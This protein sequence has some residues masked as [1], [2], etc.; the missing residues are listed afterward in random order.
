MMLARSPAG[1]S[2][3]ALGCRGPAALLIVAVLAA[4]GGAPA[5]AQTPLDRG[6]PRS[7]IYEPPPDPVPAPVPGWAPARDVGVRYELPGSAEV[8]RDFDRPVSS[9]GAGHRGIDLAVPPGEPVTVAGDGTVRHVGP[10][11]GVPWVS[12]L[13]ADGIVTSYGP[14][15]DIVVRPGQPVR[16]GQ[17][18]GVVAAGGHGDDDADRG[19]HLG[20]RRGVVY[21]DPRSLLAAGTPRPSLVGGGDWRGD[22]HVVTP[23][24]PW[25][26][27]R[28]WGLGTTPSPHAERPG[29]AVPPSPNHLV[30]LNG[31]ASSSGQTPIDPEHLGYDPR[32]VTLFSYAGRT[33]GFGEA[34]DIR[35][36]QRPYGPSDTWEGV[37]AAAERLRDQLRALRAREPGRGVDLVGHSM[38]GVVILHYLAHLHDAY[39]PTLPS[40]GRVV[41]VAAPNRGSDAAAAARY[42]REHP[43]L[44]PAIEGVR[45]VITYPD[46]STARDHLP[47]D[48]PA[49]DQLRTGS[50]FIAEHGRAWIDAVDGGTSGPLAM[51][52]RILTIGG[53]RDVVVA[54]SNAR[55]PTIALHDHPT[56]DYQGLDLQGPPVASSTVLPGG[57]GSVLDTEAVRE[58][59][60]RFLAGD[61]PPEAR[62]GV[63]AIA[64]DQLGPM[65]HVGSAMAYLYGGFVSAARRL[66]RDPARGPIEPAAPLEEHGPPRSEGDGSASSGRGE[67][68]PGAA[69]SGRAP[70]NR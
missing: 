8:V 39:D 31:L 61:E 7:P 63:S 43:V 49:V 62:G 48:A 16:R 70:G 44:A 9:F 29:F 35:R 28:F 25:E 52:T 50:S 58:I 23:Y 45:G 19:L 17:L 21:I 22:G 32:S 18:L 30:L 5:W 66:L 54:P 6:N 67:D 41:T 57:H 47:L 3:P 34:T 38:G 10:V 69:G 42:L 55:H 1:P 68:D 24:E 4:A 36:D 12:V 37:E 20:A 60:W 2:V 64:A 27:D 26:G 53:S 46:G 15:A 51:G 40:I 59:T 14:V 11:A 33:D 56:R 13:H 65:L